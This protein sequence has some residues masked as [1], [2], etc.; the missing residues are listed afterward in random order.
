MAFLDGRLITEIRTAAVS[1]AVTEYL[2]PNSRVLT[3]LASGVQADAHLEALRRVCGF[4]KVEWR[5][6]IADFWSGS[7][8]P[9]AKSW[10]TGANIPGKPRA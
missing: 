8:F 6:L 9:R 10:Y 7:L 5:K 4:E 3:L 1:A 2:A